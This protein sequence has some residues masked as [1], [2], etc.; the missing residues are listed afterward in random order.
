MTATS[1]TTKACQPR[2]SA[3]MT[4]EP[5]DQQYELIIKPMS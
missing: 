5:I 2:L 4:G 1:T 3:P